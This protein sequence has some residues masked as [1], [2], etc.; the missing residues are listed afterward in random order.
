MLTAIAADTGYHEEDTKETGIEYKDASTEVAVCGEGSKHD[1]V[2]EVY[3]PI[4][5]HNLVKCLRERVIVAKLHWLYIT[6]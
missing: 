2:D 6:W 5:R 4:E 3:A 1:I